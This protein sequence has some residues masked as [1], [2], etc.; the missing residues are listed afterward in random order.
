MEWGLM[1]GASR[2]ERPTSRTPSECA[3]RLRYAPTHTFLTRPP[4][5]AKTRFYTVAMATTLTG[6]GCHSAVIGVHDLENGV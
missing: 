6:R 1:V 4:K 2:F 3:T 5:L